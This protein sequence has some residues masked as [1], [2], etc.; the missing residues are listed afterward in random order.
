MPDAP[1][2]EL[3]DC[4]RDAL[5]RDARRVLPVTC[6]DRTIWVKR[7][8]RL[9]PLRRLQKGSAA[10]VFEAERAALH[11]LAGRGL[12]VPPILAEGPDF[13]ALPDCGPSLDHLL[14]T[15]G[16]TTETDRMAAFEAA[17]RALAG[18]HRAGVSH[19]RPSLR[20][21]CWQDGRITFLD[22]ERHAAHRNTPEGHAEDVVIFVFNGI[23]VGQGMTPELR[24]AIDSY[25]AVDPGGIWQRAQGWCR[26]RRWVATLTGPLRWRKEG[27]SNEFKAIPETLAVFSAE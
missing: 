14:R 9:S 25:R 6:G 2:P 22:F 5:A 26:R 4:I 1:D 11:A 21:I 16:A 15:P 23:R 10:A 3:I 18:L 19:G 12:P 17:G 24:R 27:K 13:F 8:E 20:D 7:L